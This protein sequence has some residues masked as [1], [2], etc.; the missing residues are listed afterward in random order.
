M[1]QANR[2]G[3]QKLAAPIK[4]A[5]L[6]YEGSTGSAVKLRER[7]LW[8][9]V[10]AGLFS[11]L[12][13]ALG[14]LIPAQGLAYEWFDLPISLIGWCLLGLILS[15]AKYGERIAA[16]V[17]LALVLPVLLGSPWWSLAG[18]LA[19]GLP[20]IG[21]GVFALLGLLSAWQHPSAESVQAGS[22]ELPGLVLITVDTLRFDHAA[23]LLA[24]QPLQAVSAAPWTLP[25]MD[26]LMLGVSAV[27]HGG[28][29]RGERGI[30][31][32][33][34]ELLAERLSR[35]GY[36][37][38]AWVC[39]PH[40]RRELGFDRG[41]DSYMHTDDWR[42]PVLLRLLVDDRFQR[43]TGRIPRIWRARDR[44]LIALAT[45]DVEQGLNGRFVWL[46]I[47]GPHEYLRDPASQVITDPADLYALAVERTAQDLAPLLQAIPAGT[48]VLIISDH[49]E[50]L[51]EGGRW[52]HG[53]ELS[54]PQL[55]V[56]AWIM[57]VSLPS[58]EGTF[59]AWDL[60]EVAFGGETLSPVLQVPVTGLREDPVQA[61]LRT[62]SGYRPL[63][64]AQG[65]VLPEQELEE[66]KQQLQG[67]GYQDMWRDTQAEPEP[68]P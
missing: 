65:W 40:L 8:A 17:L 23:Q 21:L 31:R 37:S 50:S 15:L 32:P 26:S 47:L 64:L 11:L 22:P 63:D 27:E 44:A 9:V 57:G 7:V 19:A 4:V 24:Q 10:S 48:R 58:L 18:V 54:D 39:N 33:K 51:G 67:L 28:G 29:R 35:Q 6:A 45:Q 41:F 30:T 60:P 3:G 59:F 2:G 20:R 43:W 56:P 14:L 36:A 52:G 42:D 53:T 68:T 16:G 34:G 46:H 1:H 61:A 62:P 49:G 12:E 38:S 13:A 25:A 55:L 5:S 66:L